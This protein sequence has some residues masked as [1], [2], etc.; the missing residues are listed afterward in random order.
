M[1]EPIHGALTY[2]LAILAGFRERHAALL[3]LATAAVDHHPAFSPSASEAYGTKM[4]KLGSKCHPI[5]VGSVTYGPLGAGVGYLYYKYSQDSAQACLEFHRRACQTYYYHFRSSREAVAQMNMVIAQARNVKHPDSSEARQLLRNA[6]TALHLLQ[7][8][9]TEEHPGP[10]IGSGPQVPYPVATCG[11]R[12]M[13]GISADSAGISH[14]PEDGG[15]GHRRDVPVYRGINE[16]RAEL[17]DVYRFI[18]TLKNAYYGIH[19]SAKSWQGVAVTRSAG[20]EIDRAIKLK[21]QNAAED[22]MNDKWIQG[23]RG[24]ISLT[25]SY[26]EWVVYKGA[27]L[28]PPGVS[29][30]ELDVEGYDEK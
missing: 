9:G 28:L 11:Y 22:Y 15:P 30:G 23:R 10:H 24:R 14:P 17:E 2:R 27:E 13:P 26:A 25:R 1:E 8:V 7:D 4:V 5:A 3:G 16:S 19:P 21:T 12:D 6:G 20:T 18:V 29:W